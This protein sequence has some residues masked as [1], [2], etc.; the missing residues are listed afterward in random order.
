MA[1]I[2][3]IHPGLYTDEAHASVSIPARWL[4]IGILGEADD[5]GIFEW[6]PLQLKMRVFPADSIDV[7]PLLAELAAANIIRAF[8]VDGRALGAVRNFCRYQRPRKPQARFP[9]PA[10]FRSY[11]A[12][13]ATGAE[14]DHHEDGPVPQK[15][16]LPPLQLTLVPSPSETSPQMKEEGGRMDGGGEKEPSSLKRAV[17]EIK[18]Q[19]VGWYAAYPHKVGRAAAEKQ[20][21]TARQKASLEELTDGLTSYIRAKP[22][23]RAWCNP[24]TWLCQERW[25]DQPATGGVQQSNFAST[26]RSAL[27]WVQ[28]GYQ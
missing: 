10:E 25:L 3:S 14:P 9:L 18:V 21:I 7:V 11:V 24:A 12:Q 15:S 5:N 8:E 27:D 6:K 17:D 16:E 4:W 1:R 19:F 13:G 23:D 28:E 22:T 2:R 20:F 26:P